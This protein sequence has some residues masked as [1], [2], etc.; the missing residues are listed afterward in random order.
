MNIKYRS[1][2]LHG[3]YVIIDWFLVKIKYFEKKK[4]TKNEAAFLYVLTKRFALKRS[5]K[6]HI[7]IYVSRQQY[8]HNMLSYGMIL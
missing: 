4:I 8:D 2:V 7:L 6:T 3:V 5:L 1:A